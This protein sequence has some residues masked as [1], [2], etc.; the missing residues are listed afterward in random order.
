[1]R[2]GVEMALARG[3]QGKQ[4]FALPDQKARQDCLAGTIKDTDIHIIMMVET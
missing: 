2:A 1:M 3:G 4:L